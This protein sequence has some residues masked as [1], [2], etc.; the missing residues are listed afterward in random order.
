MLTY[1]FKKIVR[2]A[3]ILFRNDFDTWNEASHQWQSNA[4]KNNYE[5][6]PW[7]D[8]EMSSKLKWYSSCEK[9]QNSALLSKT[10]GVMR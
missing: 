2:K 4:W 10:P 9:T 5:N 7:T 1:G 3:A 8:N 6:S